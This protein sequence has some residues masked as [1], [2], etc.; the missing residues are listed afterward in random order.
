[1]ANIMRYIRFNFKCKQRLSINIRS[2]SVR[3]MKLKALYYKLSNPNTPT[4][5]T[6]SML[7]D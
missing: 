3:V 2:F 7:I 4:T 1:M 5:K 6:P